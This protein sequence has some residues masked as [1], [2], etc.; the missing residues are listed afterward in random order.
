MQGYI[1][2]FNLDINHINMSTINMNEFF[3]R[4][5][6]YQR[7]AIAEPSLARDEL[8]GNVMTIVELHWS[9][10]TGCASCYFFSCFFRLLDVPS[11]LVDC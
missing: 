8:H 1:H 4:N 9:L 7:W 10:S 3:P 5:V 2:S 6:S 11:S